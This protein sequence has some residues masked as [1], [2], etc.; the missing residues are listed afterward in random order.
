MYTFVYKSL[1]IKVSK[2]SFF[3]REGISDASYSGYAN[4]TL[5]A[6]TD[7]NV[8]FIDIC[9]CFHLAVSIACVC[10]QVACF[11]LGIELFK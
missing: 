9:R 1:D 8:V 6:V 10:S 4:L 11:V 3:K 2:L 7:V 5:T